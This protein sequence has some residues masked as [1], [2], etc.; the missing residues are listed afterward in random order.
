MVHDASSENAIVWRS[1][2]PGHKDILII[3]TIRRSVMAQ[4][5]NQ[6]A[7]HIFS[8]EQKLYYVKLMKTIPIDK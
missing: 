7:A 5:K 4:Q 3:L 2:K 1:D 8:V 6:E